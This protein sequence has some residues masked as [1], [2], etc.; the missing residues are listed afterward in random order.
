MLENVLVKSKY[1]ALLMVAITLLAA[2]C[3][4]LDVRRGSFPGCL[5]RM[6][7]RGTQ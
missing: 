3:L 5:L 4:Y 6:K 7:K 2:V 1:L